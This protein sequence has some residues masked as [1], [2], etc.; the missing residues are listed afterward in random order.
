MTR[1]LD[2]WE[3]LADENYAGRLQDAEDHGLYL[4]ATSPGWQAET[5]V[6]HGTY[7]QRSLIDQDCPQC[8]R[9]ADIEYHR[10]PNLYRDKETSE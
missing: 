3:E 5:C 1:E 7:R 10:I 2:E 4:Q 9:E 6:I 8:A